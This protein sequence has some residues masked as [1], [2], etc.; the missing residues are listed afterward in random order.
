MLQRSDQG[1][2]NYAINVQQQ[3]QKIPDF[4]IKV[5]INETLPLDKISVMR[6]KDKD[7]AKF[8]AEDITQD[9]LTHDSKIEPNNAEIHMTTNDAKNNGKDWKFVVNYDVKRPVDGNDVQIGAGKFVHYFSADNLSTLPKHLIFVIDISGSMEGRK[10]EQTK[11][12]MTT[13]LGKMSENNIDNFNFVL[14]NDEVAVVEDQESVSYSIPNK[15]GDV[16]AAYDVILNLRS[17]GSTNIN[18]ALLAAIYTAEQVKKQKEI[19][20]KTQQMIV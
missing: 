16:S 19:G 3:N 9:V 11:D 2:Y 20:I 10:L 1:K 14:F 17:E 4:K 5:N 8:E 7:E 12:A 15:N 18:D 6:V 13:M